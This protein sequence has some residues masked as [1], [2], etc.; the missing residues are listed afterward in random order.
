MKRPITVLSIGFMILVTQAACDGPG[1]PTAGDSGTTATIPSDRLRTPIPLPPSPVVSP[2]SGRMRT[3]TP[4][5][6]G[7]TA[8]P[9]I[10]SYPM[11]AKVIQGQAY[12]F[13]LYTHC[14]IDQYVDFDGSFWDA[15]DSAYRET[16][17]APQGV[18]NPGQSGI[19]TLLDADHARFEFDGGSF[20]F[21]RHM[22]PKAPLG[23]Y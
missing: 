14:G 11:S 18:G 4:D 12:I 21:I 13:S 10:L 9:G 5:P 22:G 7:A 6:S 3:A 15:A 8:S 23:C 16:G 1:N 20:D 17:N 19:M 2:D